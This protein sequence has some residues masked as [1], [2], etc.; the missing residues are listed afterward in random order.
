MNSCVQW[1][2]DYGWK[3]IC[4]QQASNPDCKISRP[5]F[6]LLSFRGSLEQRLTLMLVLMC[7]VSVISANLRPKFRFIP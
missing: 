7:A 4:Q 1:K 2:V 6:Y 3:D 5:V